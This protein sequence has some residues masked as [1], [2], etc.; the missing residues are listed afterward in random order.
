[1]PVGQFCLGRRGQCSNWFVERVLV[2]RPVNIVAYNFQ[3][4]DEEGRTSQNF[5]ND[6]TSSRLGQEEAL[7]F[8]LIYCITPTRKD[9]FT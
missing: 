1:M 7:I 6:D 9:E 4:R 3:D 2:E 8:D 5:L